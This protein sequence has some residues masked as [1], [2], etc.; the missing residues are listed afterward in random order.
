MS[1][2]VSAPSNF[3]DHLG[4]C[5]RKLSNQV[6]RAFAERVEKHNVS[7]ANWVVLRLLFDHE[8]LSL[9]EIVS[10]VGVDQGALSRMVERLVV[11]ELVTRK[12]SPCSRREVAISLTEAGRKLV[13]KLAREATEN[14]RAFFN[15]MPEQQR[16]HLLSAI[17]TLLS[18]NPSNDIPLD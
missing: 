8:S 4:Y 15:R 5:L 1:A 6:S 2:Y 14:D 13:P 16:R 9:K 17:K 18:L 3:E 11:R 12:E 7:V 10:H